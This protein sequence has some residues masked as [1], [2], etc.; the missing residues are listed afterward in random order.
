MTK[1]KTEVHKERM[2]FGGQVCLNNKLCPSSMGSDGDGAYDC[3]GACT[4]S[5]TDPWCMLHSDL[6]TKV[7]LLV[8]G[9]A[10]AATA[11]VM[12]DRAVSFSFG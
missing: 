3:K 1:T 8:V 12:A 5:G 10:L 4:I 6:W 7:A 9:M 11:L 2:K